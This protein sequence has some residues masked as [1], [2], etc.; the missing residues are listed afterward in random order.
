MSSTPRIKRL[1]RFAETNF[2]S[3]CA[4]AGVLCHQ[5]QE[6][7][8]GWDYLVE[9]PDNE[10]SGSPDTRPPAKRAFVQV[11]STQGKR[12][13]C[14]IKLSNARKAAQS[15]DP[16]F[17]VLTVERNNRPRTYVI[18][19]WKDLIASFLRSV[20]QA[21][22]DNTPEHRKRLSLTFTEADYHSD[23]PVEWMRSEIERVGSEY[24]EEKRKISKTA[25][26]EDGFGTGSMIVEVESI[27]QLHNEFLGLGNG[28]S[29]SRFT[30]TP[31]RFG[32]LDPKPQIDISKGTIH[33][34][35]D[36][37][38]DCELRLRNVR[39][40][41]LATLPG[42][43]FAHSFP[44]P[45]NPERRVRFSAPGLEIKWATGSEEHFTFTLD[46]TTALDFVSL[47]DFIKIITWLQKDSVALQIWA[48]GRRVITA[49]A[50][51]N[52]PHVDCS[53]H[54]KIVGTLRSLSPAHRSDCRIS[55]AAVSASSN[56][57]FLHQVVSSPNIRIEYEPAPDTNYD[58]DTM[59]YYSVAEVGSLT[60]YALVERSLV[61]AI[62]S[63]E[64]NRH[65]ADFGPPVI[66]EG[67]V[68][69]SI[70]Q[71]QRAL[72]VEDYTRRA[73]EMDK[74]CKLIEL[75]NILEFCR[76]GKGAQSREPRASLPR[77][78]APL[79]APPQQA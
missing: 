26:Y 9:F 38:G 48:N 53:E 29:V 13:T 58:Y 49:E 4:K 71:E 34:T 18:H 15:P 33:V 8:N 20:R 77:S 67:W 31:R 62:S 6:D 1:P 36:P 50:N 23:D 42:K 19:I 28:L 64:G 37:I 3:L 47:E 61:G 21:H 45:L 43:I 70:S 25:G 76:T 57:L 32:I 7:E 10:V 30:Y 63:I 79:N 69:A 41:A 14:S 2:A 66:R 35:P 12:L 51:P 52:G 68:A 44:G 39:T 65:R 55:L 27:E 5:S 40:G 22:I 74:F 72:M 59:I 11:K 60:A 73:K 54:L 56:L 24:G 16:W 46:F 75:G 17:V 78:D